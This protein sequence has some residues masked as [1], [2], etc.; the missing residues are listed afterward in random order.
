MD[1]YISRQKAIK[2]ILNYQGG[3]VNKPIA[4]EILERLPGEDVEEVTKCEYCE[5]SS[6]YYYCNEL[7]WTCDNEEGLHRDVSPDSYCSAG[8][9]IK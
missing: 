6:V 1:D 3:S 4:Q 2:E 7:Y 9:R 5:F 8:I